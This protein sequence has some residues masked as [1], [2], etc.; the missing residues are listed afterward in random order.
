MHKIK[1]SKDSH[2]LKPPGWK[3]TG[4]SVF[5]EEKMNKPPA[6]LPCFFQ[7]S[8]TSPF[9]PANSSVPDREHMVQVRSIVSHLAWLTHAASH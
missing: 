6:E 5:K 2:I 3:Q 8:H 7:S 1:N 4:R 9:A